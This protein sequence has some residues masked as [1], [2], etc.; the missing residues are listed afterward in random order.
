M[1]NF[2]FEVHIVLKDLY[3]ELI[4]F[5]LFTA[6]DKPTDKVILKTIALVC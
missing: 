4:V 5:Y 1:L 6:V 2:G 3:L